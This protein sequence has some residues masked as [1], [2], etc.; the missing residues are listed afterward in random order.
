[1]RPATRRAAALLGLLLAVLCLIPA[2]MAAAPLAANVPSTA[3]PARMAAPSLASAPAPAVT[4]VLARTILIGTGGFTWSDVNA[5]RTPALW[6]LLR[7]G[8]SG[9]SSIRSVNPST[10]P[11]D[12]WLALSAGERAAA[13]GADGKATR[14]STA[15]C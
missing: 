2:R 15:T 9:V 10:C 11:I 4:P 1:M 12:G 7:D 8:A 13:A 6:A 14:A 3:T 5:E